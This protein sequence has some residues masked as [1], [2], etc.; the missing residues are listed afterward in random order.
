MVAA[1]TTVGAA[2]TRA[3]EAG[4]LA[5]GRR[6]DDEY[7]FGDFSYGATVKLAGSVSDTIGAVAGTVGTV[8]EG[9]L[10]SSA[11]ARWLFA[12][13]S[14]PLGKSAYR[15]NP[16]RWNT[17][18]LDAIA[19]E[20]GRQQARNAQRGV[21]LRYTEGGRGEREIELRSCPEAIEW[22]RAYKHRHG[23]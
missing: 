19:A 5:R 2:P 12:D 18:T 17:G 6:L 1:A 20:L 11:A 9:V 23:K 15:A 10:G 8:A 21:V 22:I 4:K 13:A 16:L 14:G 7:Q 3:V